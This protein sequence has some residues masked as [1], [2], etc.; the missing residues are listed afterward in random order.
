MAPLYPYL[1]AFLSMAW[2]GLGRRCIF[3]RNKHD[4][5]KRLLELLTIN[6]SLR[7]VPGSVPGFTMRLFV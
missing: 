2:H 7:P 3:E 1:V 4:T 5:L 6:Q